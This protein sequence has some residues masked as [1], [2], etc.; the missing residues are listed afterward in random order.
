MGVTSS[1]PSPC[2]SGFEINA[3]RLIGGRL[4]CG[5][6]LVLKQRVF[7]KDFL[8]KETPGGKLFLGKSITGSWIGKRCCLGNSVLWSWV[9]LIFKIPFSLWTPK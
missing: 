8:G 4:L 7:K 5:G 3:E 6:S 9:C 1:A 2:A